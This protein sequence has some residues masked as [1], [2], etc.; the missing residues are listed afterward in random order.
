MPVRAY[1]PSKVSRTGNYCLRSTAPSLRSLSLRG[2]LL[3]RLQNIRF[4]Q[5]G[6][7]CFFISHLL[8][9]IFCLPKETKEAFCVA[10][11]LCR[12]TLRGFKPTYSFYLRN[13]KKSCPIFAKKR[14]VIRFF[15][16]LSFKTYIS[17]SLK[18]KFS[19]ISFEDNSVFFPADFKRNSVAAFNLKRY[20]IIR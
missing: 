6:G 8:N 15:N 4:V 5:V 12:N 13:Q 10:R 20:I 18:S 2:A 7:F 19:G 11:L 17:C 3:L 9:C 14:A 1:I 16:N